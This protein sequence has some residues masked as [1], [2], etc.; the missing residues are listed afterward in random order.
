MLWVIDIGNTNIVSGVHDGEKWLHLWRIQTHRDK[1]PDEYAVLFRAL[2]RE[3]GLEPR[4]LDRAVISSVVPPL[5]GT[6]R[7]VIERLCGFTPLIVGPHLDTGIKILLDNPLE[8]GSD[9]LANAVA[10]YQRMKGACIVVDF[11]TA[12]SV[13]AVSERGEFLG[14]A[15]AP[16]L[17]LAVSALAG[18]TAQLPAIPLAAP[19]RAIGTGTI[20]AIQ[21]G[22]VYGYIG[23]IEGLV[24][25][26]RAEMGC[27]APVIATGGLSGLMAEH[28]ALFRQVDVGLTLEG[29]RLI[30]ERNRGADKG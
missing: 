13:I 22:I 10:G 30:A 21:S 7:E 9:L 12:T 8:I 16:G 25:R 1:M 19:P 11:G 28:T 18:G 29:I 3:V 17:K 15:I 27:Q 14:G 6:L 5:T 24:Q 26:F 20:T 2:L 23:L 4:Q